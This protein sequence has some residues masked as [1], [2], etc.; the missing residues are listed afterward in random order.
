MVVVV[1]CKQC[2]AMNGQRTPNPVKC[3]R[4]WHRFDR[5]GLNG[6]SVGFIPRGTAAG[7]T[8]DAPEPGGERPPCEDTGSGIE[9]SSEIGKLAIPVVQGRGGKG[10]SKVAAL[11]RCNAEGHTGFQREDG[12]WCQTCRRK[13]GV[14]SKA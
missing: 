14:P 11:L 4:C 10:K 3:T 1:T 8:G 7:V 6:V 12:Y 2:G 5:G 9:P 13:Y